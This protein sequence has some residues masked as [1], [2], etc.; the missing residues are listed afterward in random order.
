MSHIREF[1]R[2]PRAMRKGLPNNTHHV[3]PP[4]DKTSEEKEPEST[5]SEDDLAEGSRSR[6]MSIEEAYQ[7]QSNA[8]NG[9]RDG[10]EEED[11]QPLVYS[12]CSAV[13]SVLLSQRQLTR[14]SVE[15]RKNSTSNVWNNNIRANVLSFIRANCHHLFPES[16]LQGWEDSDFLYH[17]VERI[18]IGETSDGSLNP[19]SDLEEVQLK[20]HTCRGQDQCRGCQSRP[21]GAYVRMLDE[22]RI[23]T[24]GLA[25]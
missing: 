9:M 23:A 10:E 15:V 19:S 16:S 4:Q 18:K 1:P 20:V 2:P 3:S 14:S 22:Y 25:Q 11:D 8:V 24:T 7:E 5:A 6:R 17:H 13:T 21:R 12:E